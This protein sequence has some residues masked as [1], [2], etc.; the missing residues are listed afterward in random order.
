MNREDARIANV[1]RQ[2]AR[3]EESLFRMFSRMEVSL[4]QSDSQMNFMMQM[5]T[6]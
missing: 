3:R 1:T 5:F 2:L 4:M 6:Q